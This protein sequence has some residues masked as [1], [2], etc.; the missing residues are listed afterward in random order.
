MDK[1]LT[2]CTG[3][4]ALSHAVEAYVSTASSPITDTFALEA[5]K[6]IG[7]YLPLSINEP[8]NVDY[9]A[10][11]LMASLQAGLAFSNASLGV[12]HS[13]AH[14][15]GGYLDLAHG[16]CNSMLLN[17]VVDYNYSGNEERY[18]SIALALG[19]SDSEV[20]TAEHKYSKKDVLMFLEDF[21]LS[22][23]INTRLA[24]KNVQMDQIPILAKKAIKDPCNATNPRIPTLKDIE[25]LYSEAL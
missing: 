16:E 13:M 10:E 3:M 5:I 23:G 21:K 19:L 20:Y 18:N 12:I 6:L 15:L 4:D 14:S 24:D 17:T 9:R 8:D 11:V 25:L 2:A 7:K 22:V 1:Y